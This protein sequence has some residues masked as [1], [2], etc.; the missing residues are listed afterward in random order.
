[1]SISYRRWTAAACTQLAVLDQQR[2][3][4]GQ[5]QQ[6]SR[7]RRSWQQQQRASAEPSSW[8]QHIHDAWHLHGQV[9][10]QA[11]CLDLRKQLSVNCSEASLLLHGVCTGN[12]SYVSFGAWMLL[13]VLLTGPL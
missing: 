13:G 4:S 12:M 5:Q 11:A 1:M 3:C 6:Q 9:G 2:R 10:R 7:Q 8:A